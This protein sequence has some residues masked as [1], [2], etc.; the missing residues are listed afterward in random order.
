MVLVVTACGASLFALCWSLLLSRTF[1]WIPT[2]RLG[3]WSNLWTRVYWLLPTRFSTAWPEMSRLGFFDVFG[4]RRLAAAVRVQTHRPVRCF[5]CC[6]RFTFYCTAVAAIRR[7]AAQR[8]PG[9]WLI[10]LYAICFVWS[11]CSA[12][13]SAQT[14]IQARSLCCD[15]VRPA[16]RPCTRTLRCCIR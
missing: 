3:F 12:S 8:Y 7:A 13:L 16:G 9:R 5:R 2:H 10:N 11:L 1:V 6:T 14:P 15:E 4:V